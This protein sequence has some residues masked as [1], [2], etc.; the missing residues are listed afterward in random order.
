MAN[1]PSY[2]R[3]GQSK[4]YLPISAGEHW[5]FDEK[6]CLAAAHGIAGP[7]LAALAFITVPGIGGSVALYPIPLTLCPLYMY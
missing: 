6:F 2:D 3:L 5:C 1:L 4:D 7:K